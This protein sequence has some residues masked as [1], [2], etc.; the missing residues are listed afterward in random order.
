[1]RRGAIEAWIIQVTM[2]LSIAAIMP[3]WRSPIELCAAGVD[4]R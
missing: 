3:V 1:M 4:Q 2:T